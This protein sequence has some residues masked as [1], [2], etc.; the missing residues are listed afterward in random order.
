[1]SFSSSLRITQ[2][3]PPNQCTPCQTCTDGLTYQT[4]ACT[5]VADRV[6]RACSPPCTGRNYE[7][8]ACANGVNRVCSACKTCGPNNYIFSDCSNT[9][10]DDT[11]VCRPCLT[12]ADCVSQTT[13]LL[14][15]NVCDGTQP[16]P[17]HCQLCTPK[18]CNAGYYLQ[19]CASNSDSTC[20]PYT[21]CDSG[22][23]LANRDLYADGV[24][25]PCS[26]CNTSVSQ[27][28]TQYT[29]TLCLGEACNSYTPCR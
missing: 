10:H 7:S 16:T 5:T 11:T 12:G 15:T 29:D 13:F 26:T 3:D 9:E 25:T 19:K 22:F 18:A 4:Q 23:Y 21:T 27:P 6:C 14:S 28:C 8:T 1:V 2:D 17:N 24:C 20:V